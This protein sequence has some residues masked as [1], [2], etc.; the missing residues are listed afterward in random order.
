[1]LYTT[2]FVSIYVIGWLICAFIPWLVLSI[3]T[4]GNAGL[5]MLPLCL[6]AGV[7]GALAVPVFGLTGVTGFWLSFVVAALVPVALLVLRRFALHDIGATPTRAPAP[8]AR[9]TEET[10]PK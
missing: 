1:M 7:I 10:R 6:F 3:A 9:P 2:I 5:G 8:I 4:K